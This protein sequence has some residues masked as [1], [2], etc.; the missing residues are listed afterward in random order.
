MTTRYGY[1][2][3]SEEHPPQESGG[4]DR[5]V[6]GG[7]TVCWAPDEAQARKTMHRLWPTGAIPGE[8]AQ[9][10]P[11]LREEHAR[12]H[13]SDASADRLSAGITGGREGLAR[14]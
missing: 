9:L 14:W 8:A 6:Q 2:L 5:A 11:R 3:S 7:L 1:F 12:S 13:R 10:L 4:G